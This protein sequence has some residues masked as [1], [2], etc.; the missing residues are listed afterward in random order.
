[1]S[2][3]FSMPSLGAD[4]EDGTLVRW[5]VAPG[6]RVRKGDTVALVETEKGIIDIESFEDGVI[7]KLVVE[8]GTRVPVGTTLAL[9]AGVPA[10]AAMP[11]PTSPATPT[12]GPTPV[13]TPTPT[14]AS[15]I[16]PVAAVQPAPAPAPPAYR[17]TRISPAA[18]ARAA[19]LGVDLAG[20]AGS[21]PG[22]TVVID[23]VDRAAAAKSAPAAAPAAQSP[24]AGVRHAIAASMSRSK[25]EIPHYYLSLTMDFGAAARWLEAYNAARPVPERLLTTVL[26]IKA[27]AR[28]AAEK[29]AFNGFYG[30]RGFEP[31][32][33]VHP[34]VAI[35]MRGGGLVAPAISEA[36]R[37]PLPVLMREL[38][39]L[40]ARV[41]GGHLRSGELASATLTMTSLG[42]DGV[43]A[44]FPIIHPPQV[45]IVGFGSV[46]ER[47]WVVDGRVE[48][49]PVMTLTLAADH[50]VSD[51]R[52]GA[53]FLARIRDL[54]SR[55]E[56][57]D[58]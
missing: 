51:G 45:A 50:R 47:P 17:G 36:N 11:P 35:A 9:F 57:L 30:P 1:M 10:G 33:G 43:D 40:V 2:R 8:P 53:K 13:P 37:K 4:M 29:P 22:G 42:D 49:R 31:A 32:R 23:D 21:G 20:L 55:P 14:P 28:A 5:E 25:R 7:E 52:E 58:E 12:P 34:G 44:L 15:A 18:R 26:L 24:G 54:L 39:E 56:A 6:T 38:Q 46:L 27:L 3:E 16:P 19:E 48:P 41:R